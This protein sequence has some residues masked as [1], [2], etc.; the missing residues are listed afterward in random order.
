MAVNVG[1]GAPA[2]AKLISAK[3]QPAQLARQCHRLLK[4]SE[5]LAPFDRVTLRHLATS[6]ISAC[7]RDASRTSFPREKEADVKYGPRVKG[8]RSSFCYAF[9]DEMVGLEN[10]CASTPIQRPS[11][12]RLPPVQATASPQPNTRVRLKENSPKQSSPLRPTCRNSSWQYGSKRKF[13]SIRLT[14]PT[15]HFAAEFAEVGG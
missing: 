14:N 8:K 15:Y 12:G 2:L 7:V 9:V 10:N 6:F 11:C 4:V 5:R 1:Q 3:G 13:K